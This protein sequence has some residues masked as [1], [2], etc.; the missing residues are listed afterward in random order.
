[1]KHID[2]FDQ[3]FDSTL[4]L[5]KGLI[6]ITELNFAADIQPTVNKLHRVADLLLEIHG[7][8]YEIEAKTKA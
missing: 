8:I 7:E 2:A 4:A 3:A 6:E 5:Q 1:M